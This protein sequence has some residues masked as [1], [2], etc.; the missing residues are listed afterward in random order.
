MTMWKFRSRLSADRLESYTARIKD[1]RVT[2]DILLRERDLIID[3]YKHHMQLL[4]QANIFVFAV[5]GALASFVVTHPDVPHIR[6][7]FVFP[8]VFNAA[9]AVFFWKVGTGL[10]YNQQELDQLAGALGV[11]IVPTLRAL[12][13]GLWG[14]AAA[15]AIV[16]MLSLVALFII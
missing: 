5:T 13:L 2:A 4:L 10:D 11:N 15:L 14:S 3:L 9:F 12:Q 1:G 6:L 7:I 8:S 16:S